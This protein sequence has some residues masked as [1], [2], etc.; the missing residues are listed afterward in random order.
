MMVDLKH[1]ITGEHLL[2]VDASLLQYMHD[3][4]EVGEGS[5]LGI[6]ILCLI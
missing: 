5:S 3:V 6:R 4:E 2:D 1:V